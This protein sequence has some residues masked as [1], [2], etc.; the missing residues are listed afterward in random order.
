LSLL[1]AQPKNSQIIELCLLVCSTNAHRYK[2]SI[3]AGDETGDTNFIVFGRWAQRMIKKQVDTLIASNPRGFL[4]DDITRLLEKVYIWNVSFTQN[5]KD[6]IE[7]CFQVNAL[8]G[9]VNDGST[10]PA[11]PAGSQSSSLMLSQGSGSS[12]QSTP[13]KSAALPLTL[14]LPATAPSHASSASHDSSA[15]PAKTTLNIPGQPITP[16]SDSAT[17]LNEVVVTQTI[18][19]HFFKI[20]S[21]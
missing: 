1:T 6:S 17:N 13:Q 7:E 4:P 2:L 16:Q 18:C 19:I 11:T 9:E 20:L 8:I 15:T 5:S 14:L 12:M 10:L 3:V 21:I